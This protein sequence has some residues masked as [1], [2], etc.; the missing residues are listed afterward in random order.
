[1][2]LSDLSPLWKLCAR[3][4]EYA[5]VNCERVGPAKV[6]QFELR[7]R[8]AAKVP[9]QLQFHTSARPGAQGVANKEGEIDYATM[10]TGPKSLT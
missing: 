10:Q 1:M 6:V 5:G 3:R 7:N 9:R 8:Q 4:G 2:I